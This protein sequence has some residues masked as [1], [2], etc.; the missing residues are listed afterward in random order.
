MKCALKSEHEMMYRA[1]QEHLDVDDEEN[2]AAF[3]SFFSFFS[4]FVQDRE[5]S[6]HPILLLT[7]HPYPRFR[8]SFLRR[9]LVFLL[10]TRNMH[11]NNEGERDIKREK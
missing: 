9:T 10:P 2:G 8:P 7:S 4:S 6:P 1:S 3:F 5:V 11:A